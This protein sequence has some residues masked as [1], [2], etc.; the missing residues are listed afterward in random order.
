MDQRKKEVL[1][2]KRKRKSSKAKGLTFIHIVLCNPKTKSPY[3]FT[4]DT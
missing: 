1:G 4:V 2:Q 3:V